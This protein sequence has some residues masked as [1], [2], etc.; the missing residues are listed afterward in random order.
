MRRPLLPVAEGCIHAALQAIEK[1]ELDRV[2]RYLRMALEDVRDHGKT[3][4]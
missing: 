4:E 2:E 3:H 1:G